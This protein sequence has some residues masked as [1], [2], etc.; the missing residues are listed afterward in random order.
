MKIKQC[1]AIVVLI[2]ICSASHAQYR[3]EAVHGETEEIVNNKKK[4]A[5]ATS[6]TTRS[7]LSGTL[8]LNYEGINPDSSLKYGKASL[9]LA[10]KSGNPHYLS[11]ALA[12]LSGTLRSQ[13]KFVEALDFLYKALN[14]AQEYDLKSDIARSYRRL[15]AVYSQ[16]E[17]Y[18]KAVELDRAALI[19]DN[20]LPGKANQ[21]DHFFLAEAF[22]GLN[23]LDSALAHITMP[24][25][26][27]AVIKTEFYGTLGSIYFKMGNY[28]AANV[29]YHKSYD[30]SVAINN[31]GD[32]AV[33]C[34]RLT[35][36]YLKLNKLDSAVYFAKKGFALGQKSSFKKE[37]MRAANALAVIYDSTQ[38]ALAL[39]YIKIANATKDS[40][41]GA[42]TIETIENLVSQEQAR[43]KELEDARKSFKNRLKWYAA[44]SA[45]L[46]LLIIALILFRNNKQKQK[47]NFDLQKQKEKV[48]ST[49]SKLKST[50]V[51]LIQSEKMA[52]LG[53]LTAGIAHEIQNPLNFVNNFSEVSKELLDEMKTE[54]D[55]GHAEDAKAIAN[56]IIQNLEKINHHGK[57]ADAIVKNMLQH[58]RTS[59][60][61]KEPTAINALADEYLRLSYQGLRAKDKSFNSIIYTNYDDSVGTM[62]VIPQ[63]IGRVLLNLLNNAFYSVNEK[64]KY[65]DGTFEPT[66]SVSTK[67]SGNKIEISVKDNGTGIPQKV[68]DKI[69]QPFFTTKPPGEGTGLGLSLSY[70]IITKGHGGELK[71]ETK[72]G[73]GS[74]FIIQLPIS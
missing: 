11:R 13:G 6:D 67:R 7:L 12:G 4:L 70:D 21:I 3:Q 69:Y 48:E 28:Q 25:D 68:L 37:K 44:L 31:F 17:N 36:M 27:L 65:M 50:Q 10:E 51:Q 14:I 73:E 53:E 29:F 15:G 2:S 39:T 16:L 5:S 26:T 64:K 35:E 62:E 19:I 71:V 54:L 52:S 9:Q 23:K 41:F 24:K 59:T 43:Q 63:D 66:V 57:R 61:Q 40:L 58:S 1:L 38:P 18:T 72:E 33:A 30:S 34:N 42:S 60:N 55:A 49:L 74:M 32:A 20:A 47:I 22:V 46:G 8:A 56:D 45:L